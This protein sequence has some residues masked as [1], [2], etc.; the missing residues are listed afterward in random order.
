MQLRI[1]A[2][3]SFDQDG[4][5]IHAM[6]RGMLE[7]RIR[8][9]VGEA[10]VGNEVLSRHVG[11]IGNGCVRF[12]ECVLVFEVE[13]DAANVRLGDSAKWCLIC[14]KMSWGL[15]SEK[16]RRGQDKQDSEV[17]PSSSDAGYWRM[18]LSK[19]AIQRKCRRS[20]FPSL[21]LK[22]SLFSSFLSGT[23]KCC[24]QPSHKSLLFD[25]KVSCGSLLGK[26]VLQESFNQGLPDSMIMMTSIHSCIQ[27]S[28]YVDFDIPS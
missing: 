5:G 1:L 27:L 23:S 3:N 14:Y 4:T 9:L 7:V 16:K 18:K 28:T 2:A 21:D 6:A 24:F 13:C 20:S 12:P 11:K 15:H 25:N 10:R 26:V 22:I 8:R 17:L 19:D